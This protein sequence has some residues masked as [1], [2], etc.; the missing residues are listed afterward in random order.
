M[1]R[2]RGRK[3]SFNLRRVRVTVGDALDTLASATALVT[4]ITP[5]SVST[6][7]LV[8]AKLAWSLT[9]LTESD[10]PIVVGYAHSDYTV[11]EIKEA[12]ESQNSIN[13]GDKIS[14]EQSNRLVRI[15]GSFSGMENQSLNDGRPIKTK[16]NWLIPIGQ[17]VN[18]F[19]YNDGAGALTTGS[20][21]RANG[22]IWVKDSV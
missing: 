17:F 4:G 19:A 5:A 10:G 7:R 16:L 12:I 13:P 8:S 18:M 11:G 20:N 9:E 3:R 15:V 22:D 21:L 6:Y 2:K 1:A 14:Q